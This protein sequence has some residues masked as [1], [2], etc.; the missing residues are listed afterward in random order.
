MV[1]VYSASRDHVGIAD[2]YLLKYVQLLL[3]PDPHN[4]PHVFRLY[5]TRAPGDSFLLD[6]GLFV[7]SADAM[8]RDV[9]FVSSTPR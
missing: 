9:G 7:S 8:D 4:E 2:A 3:N 5:Q 1:Q 6:A